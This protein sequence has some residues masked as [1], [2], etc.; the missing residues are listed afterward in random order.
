MFV[1]LTQRTHSNQ[2]DIVLSIQCLTRFRLYWVYICG[3]RVVLCVLVVMVTLT[4]RRHL[5]LCTLLL[6]VFPVHTF[7][8]LRK[9]WCR[10]R[11]CQNLNNKVSFEIFSKQTSQC[12]NDN[13]SN[14]W[15]CR[16]LGEWKR[17]WIC[18]WERRVWIN[19]RLLIRPNLAGASF[20]FNSDETRKADFHK[21]ASSERN[22][23]VVDV[24]RESCQ[25]TV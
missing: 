7:K 18:E 1:L 6:K 12:K 25:S 9:C 8:Y 14:R 13:Y 17:I 20:F 11:S 23:D 2:D 21:S 24:C 4:I 15:Q 5:L 10:F 3:Q 22:P 19:L 16:V